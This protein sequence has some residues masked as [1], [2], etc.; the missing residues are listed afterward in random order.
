MFRN[1][2]ANGSTP[3]RISV[4][5]DGEASLSGIITKPSPPAT[6]QVL[7]LPAI[8]AP[9]RDYTKVVTTT[10]ANAI[11]VSGNNAGVIALSGLSTSDGTVYL[12]GLTWRVKGS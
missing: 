1:T 12:D 3:L 5:A 4:S 2:W 10:S 6:E 11:R 7:A 9:D 8:I